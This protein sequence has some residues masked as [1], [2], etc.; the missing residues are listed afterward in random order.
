ME[1]KENNVCLYM[2]CKC[3]CLVSLRANGNTVLS[4]TVTNNETCNN[5]PFV[6]E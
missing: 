4:F 5:E 2:I 6:Y 3:A 1:E